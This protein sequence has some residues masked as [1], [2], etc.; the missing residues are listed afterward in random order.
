MM[1]KSKATPKKTL[2]FQV[3][4]ILYQRLLD[5]AW[6][7]RITISKLLRDCCEDSLYKEIIEEGKGLEA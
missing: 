4:R 5:S 2:G 7:K 1:K 6:S 3:D